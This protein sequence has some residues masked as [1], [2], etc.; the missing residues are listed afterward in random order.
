MTSPTPEQSKYLST[1][2]DVASMLRKAQVNM[3]KCPKQRL[4]AGYVKTRIKTIEEYWD[5]FKQT[6]SSLMKCTPREQRGVLPYFLN[7]EYY[8]YEE[9][10]LCLQADLTDLLTNLES[11][12][13]L[14]EASN[15]SSSS[16][17]G[18]LPFAK[19]P[20]IQL[21]T[22]SGRYE[23]WPTYKDI[24][25]ALVHNTSIS[26]VR[27]LHY[28]KTSVAGEAEML[29]RHVQITE[30]N[31]ATA[32][33]LLQG[34][35]GSKKMIVSSVLKKFCCQKKISNPSA[36]Q[37][38]A[39]LDNT[40]ECI[41]SLNN[42]NINTTTWDPILVFLVTQKLDS[43]TLKCWEEEAYKENSDELSTWVELKKFL[44][45]KFRTLE[46]IAPITTTV[47]KEKTQGHKAYHVVAKE[48]EN[49]KGDSAQTKN[50]SSPLCVYCKGDHY[51]FSCKEF[52][53]QTVEQRR[54]FVKNKNLCFNCLIPNHIVYKCKQKRKCR[55]C[56]RKH[57]SL[58]HEGKETTQESATEESNKQE[59]QPEQKV[60]SA[61]FSKEQ[62]GRQVLLATAQ[63]H[64]TSSDGNTYVLRA[65]IDQGSEASFVSSRVVELLRLKRT[66]INGVVSGV[67]E[68]NLVPIKHVVDLSVAS[69]HNRREVIQ[70]KAYVLKSLST[71][72]PSK[73]ITMN[74]PEL[75]KLLLADPTYNTPGKID[76]LLGADIFSKIIEVGLVRCS[77]G[78]VAQ[79]TRLGWIL[80]GEREDKSISD[81][82]K[83]TTL[84]VTS[85]V[86]EDNDLLRKFWEIETTLYKKRKLLTKEEEMCEEIYKNTTK[87]V[88]GKY[89]VHLPLRQGIEE[90]LKLCGDTKQQA[91]YRFKQLEKK[92]QNSQ[93][94]KSDYTKVVHEYME[95]GHLKKSNPND[96]KKS[97][98]LP[99]HA[100]IR[101]DKDTTKVR[102]V[103]DA[104]AKGSNGHSLND[105]MMIGP[106]L[107][108]DLRS[109]II[110]WRTHKI[111]VVGDIIKMYRMINMTPEHTNLQRIVWRDNPEEKL[112]SFNLMTVTFGT[113]AAPF[114][115]VRTLQ[116]LA[117]D[118][119][120][121][122]PNTAPVIKE[123]FYMDDLMSG[124]EN[125]EKTKKMCEEIKLILSKGNFKM[126]KW[127]SNSEEVL[128]FLKEGEDTNST[129]DGIEIK[130]D[131]VIKILGL[132]WDRKDDTFKFTINLPEISCPVTKRSILSD[133][134]RLFDPFG[135]LSPVIINAKVLIQKLWLCNMGWDDEL[136]SELMDDWMR[137]REELVH[138]QNITIPRWLKT[139]PNNYTNIELHGFADAS[140][141]AY[142]AVTYLKIIEEETVHITI[143]ASRTKVAPLKQISIPKLEL[144]AAALLTD[145]IQDLV[146]LL[147]IPKNKIFAWTDS[148]I[149]MSWLQSQPSR[150]RTFV[151]NRVADITRMLDNDRWRHVQ[152][153]D[154]PAD[155]ATRGVKAC[156]LASLDLWWTGPVWLKHKNLDLQ[157]YEIPQ[158]ELE[159]KGSSFHTNVGVTP[160][161]EHFSSISRMKRIL[162]YCRRFAKRETEKREMYLTV[163]ELD[164][165]LELCIKYYQDLVYQ[166]DIEE[167]QKDG[168]VKKRSSL[169]TLAPFLDKNGLIRVGG[170]LENASIADITKH[171]IVIPC[172]QHIT[173]LLVQEAHFRTL[174]GGIQAMM[175]FVR[176]KY[177]V[178]GLKSAVRKCI[179]NCKTCILDKAKVKTQFMGQLPAV[180]VNQHRPF[181]NSGVDYAGP[182]FIRTSKGRGHHATKGY[183]C[184]FICMATRA[185]H[186]EAVTDLTTQAFI[187]AFRRFVA[188]RGH[189]SNLWSD[190]GTNFIGA[191]K[192]L[193]DMFQKGKNNIAKEAA[194]L[195][196][197][198]NTIWHFIPPRMPTCGGLW[199]AG[200]QSAKRH[201]YRINK[202]TKLTYEEMSTL[203]A[204]IEACLNSR[205]L[206]QM[207]NS[208]MPLTPG[209]FL[210]GEPL[211]S[212][213]DTCYE[214][215]P[216]SILTRW[217]IIQKMTQDFWHRW[218]TEYL[219]TLQQRYKWQVKVPEPVVGD[220]VIIKEDNLPPTKW[221]LGRVKQ[222]HPG[223]DKLVRVVTVQTM[224]NKEFKRPLY[225]LIPLPKETP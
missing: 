152:S 111:C 86:S 143:I 31:Y 121:E 160:I 72:L 115:A 34:R 112:E 161:W 169:I 196:A 64:A 163:N 97:V 130:L 43:E 221:L 107:Q 55:V 3:K 132:T 211:I 131:K 92:L 222:I 6:H 67:G 225:K 197:N 201:L 52:A 207:D 77:D 95:M 106:V 104:S 40:V 110:T 68:G 116:Q 155:I 48:T 18:Q 147:K 51:I 214:Y 216:V 108:P 209:H 192:E 172:N 69:Q 167:L 206:Y 15:M 188:R 12:H 114:L 120:L 199:E 73:H 102:V 164:K 140:T 138:L 181:M 171:P 88:N 41:N 219:N 200:V 179:H 139:T 33:E 65:L 25:T 9:M 205:P 98:Y 36:T 135:W 42:M 183:I 204:Q 2:E 150:W 224:G 59:E 5:S 215:Q 151:A 156:D 142:A 82:H 148:M 75:Q 61:H 180:R 81:E 187:A 53:K 54:E 28:L 100:V 17:D 136:P 223:K 127:S 162:A 126:Q 144:C 22:F 93:S 26:D 118:E 154:N 194:E 58:L 1:L 62:P 23:E 186:L 63:V 11:Q 184:L 113:A 212:V 79:K 159:L 89:T 165:V 175:A 56:G 195:L 27:K 198:D 119:A 191:A 158:T 91:I 32:W 190:N 168:S 218:R 39:L 202:E 45:S 220:V 213:P 134:A 109:L 87:R 133:V 189:C 30:S 60:T 96:D 37:I 129:K 149:V 46:L 103:Y 80:S 71:R 178:I 177:W 182:V 85:M 117:D 7:E 66:S 185:I 38:K 123:S 128:K 99:H 8:T 153:T 44:E 24:F 157:T 13:R 193:K 174:H 35:F 217:Q 83:I 16:H 49:D 173:K 4:T 105:T 122:Y 47:T 124:S 19:L 146:D 57:H 78:I 10:Y 84:H 208:I 94:L 50:S 70:V 141:Q 74:W 90:T 76:I 101:E 29:L 203:L 210:V 166:K 20:R 137:Y 176:T 21:P 170:R 145:L 14:S 125:E